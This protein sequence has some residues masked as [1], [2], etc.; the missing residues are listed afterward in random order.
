MSRGNKRKKEERKEKKIKK[1]KRKGT[2]IGHGVK[3]RF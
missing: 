2:L 3:P 1:D